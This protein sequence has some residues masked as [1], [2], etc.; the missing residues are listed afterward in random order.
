MNTVDGTKNSLNI[1]IK[2][3]ISKKEEGS[4]RYTLWKKT[5]F[6]YKILMVRNKI[7]YSAL[8]K[9]QGVNELIIK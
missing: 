6:K 3:K 4:I 1:Y 9:C 5:C 8:K 2:G 7:S